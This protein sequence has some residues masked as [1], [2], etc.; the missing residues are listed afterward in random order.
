MKL[1]APKEKVVASA[2][3]VW[4]EAFAQVAETDSRVVALTA[5]LSRSTITEIFREKFPDRYF[6]V[7]VAEQNMVGMAAGL[8]LSGKI[9]FCN[10]FAPFAAMRAGEQFRTDA[11]YMHLNVRLVAGYAGI[12]QPAGPTH[13]GLEDAGIIRGMPG[14]AVVSPSDL[15][16]VKK[17]FEASLEYQGPMY[18]RFGLGKNEPYL[19]A[20]DYDFVIG[21]AIETR[22][23]TDATIIT[24]G[25]ILQDALIAAEK[26][27][28][29]GI[30]TAVL[31]M[32]TLK[33]LDTEAVISAARRTGRVLTMER[34]SILNGL[35]SAVA[36][37][38]MEAGV[39]C[40]F[41]RLGIP[42]LY[43]SYGDP[44]RLADK[45][46]FGIPAAV[47]TIA[48]WVRES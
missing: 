23:G 26:L 43:P 9:P 7:G 22:P 48:G 40:R 27:E 6:N 29:M 21:K 34:H 33:P 25:M 14:S 17:I 10:T 46:G 39:P 41:K 38:L 45:Y 3:K 8:A 36:E 13:S 18:L 12:S 28:E 1:Y 35:G 2:R 11:C 16:M 19:Y 30:S 44:A 5:D 37:T 24:H 31:D 20:E 42:D 32:H 4:C 47:D 15:S